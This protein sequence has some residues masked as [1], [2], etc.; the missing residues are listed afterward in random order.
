ME[1]FIFV[2]RRT[3]SIDYDE[4][5]SFVVIAADENQARHQHPRPKYQIVWDTRLQVWED[6]DGETATYHGWTN[7]PAS[8]TVTCIGVASE[9]V[10]GVVCDSFNAG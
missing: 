5:D 1:N 8:L 7:D 4:F 2:V 6:R 10:S 9:G 3:D